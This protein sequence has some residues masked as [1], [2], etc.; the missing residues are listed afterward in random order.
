MAMT[1][2]QICRFEK[3]AGEL[4]ILQIRMREIGVAQVPFRSNRVRPSEI[5]TAKIES[6]KVR[7]E[8]GDQPVW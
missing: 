7:V 4:S 8:L 1:L 5:L 2:G 3:S 6:R